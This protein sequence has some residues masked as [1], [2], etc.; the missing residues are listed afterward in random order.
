[1]HLIQRTPP[2]R[3]FYKLFAL[4]VFC[5]LYATQTAHAQLKINIT[6]VDN[7]QIP[8]SVV[9]FEGNTGL[10]EDLRTVIQAD[11]QRSGFFKAVNSNSNTVLNEL[12]VIDP[13]VW[14]S[15]GV[16]ALVVGSVKRLADGRLDV[17]FNLHDTS[18]QK[19]L[20]KLSYVITPSALRLTGHKIADYI[21]EKLLGEPGVFATRV[22]YV[23]KQPGQHRLIIADA[24]GANPQV[25]LTSKEPIIS[26]SWSPDGSQLAYVSF[27]TK[28]PVIFL[29]TLATGQR[30]VVA[31]F[32]GSNS[33]PAWS[34]NGQMAVVLTKDNGS[35]IYTLRPDGSNLQKLTNVGGIN[36]EPTYSHDGKSIYFTSDRGGGPQIYR[37]DTS[38]GNATRVTFEGGYNISPR[39]SPDGKNLTYVT[40]RDGRFRIAILDLAGGSDMLLT[41]TSRDE[42]PSFSPNGRYV[43]YATRSGNSGVLAVVSNDGRIRYELKSS[44]ANITEPTWGPFLKND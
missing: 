32:K 3:L 34:R 30:K 2:N 29:H 28:K 16:D 13:T 20:G 12:S 42:S 38:G 11:L 14:K 25:A 31:N 44:N 15:I 40:R 10:P 23:E 17:R 37:M 39:V 4:L 43:L 18:Q 33:A 22:A 35:Q 41:D 5:V 19:S 7:N 8:F 27:E 24:D 6:G 9:P 1:M 36:T 21:Y 26:P